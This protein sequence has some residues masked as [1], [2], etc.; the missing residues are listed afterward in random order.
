[1]STE[2]AEERLAIGMGIAAPLIGALVAATGELPIDVVA[3]AVADRDAMM[4]G[5]AQHTVVNLAGPATEAA[6]PAANGPPAAAAAP[7]APEA[8]AAPATAR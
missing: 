4:R 5:V 1:M 8:A 3:D 6:G 2:G 7:Q